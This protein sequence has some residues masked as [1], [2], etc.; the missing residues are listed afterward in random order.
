MNHIRRQK[1]V[2]VV[3]RSYSPENPPK[4]GIRRFPCRKEVH[5][6]VG[7]PL[8]QQPNIVFNQSCGVGAASHSVQTNYIRVYPPPSGSR[9]GR[10]ITTWQLLYLAIR[11]KPGLPE[12]GR[13]RN[14]TKVASGC[15]CQRRVTGGVA[16]VLGVPVMGSVPSVLLF[17]QGRRKGLGAGLFHKRKWMSSSQ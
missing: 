5:V 13:T 15:R 17:D 4:S 6:G 16:F 1:W 7:W 14:S 3:I 9:R 8:Y 12:S 11:R 2:L 10:S